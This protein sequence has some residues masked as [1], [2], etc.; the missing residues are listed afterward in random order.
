MNTP[1]FKASHLGL[2]FGGVKAVQDVSFTV[3]E[4][5][6]FAIIGP[7][8]AGKTTILNLIS[9][10]YDTEAGG[11]MEIAGQD[12]TRIQASRVAHHGIART[13]QNTELFKE[14][15]GGELHYIPALNA[16]DDH[17]SFLSRLVEKNVGGW[18][19]ASPDWSLS[20]STQALD[21]SLQ[22]ARAMGADS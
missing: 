6:V 9:R 5:E 1:L 14:A 3:G 4:G 7:N 22:R 21:K 15:G 18:P 12:I 10:L 8:G 13:F 20:E 2:S 19:E 17:V 11:H 16:R